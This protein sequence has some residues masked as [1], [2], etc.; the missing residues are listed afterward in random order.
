MKRFRR[1]QNTLEYI[2]IFAVV[3]GGIIA[4]GA[5]IFKLKLTDIYG[6]FQGK[7]QDKVGI[8]DNTF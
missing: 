1:G 3:V 6:K 4:I 7:V 8:K 2:V 5:G